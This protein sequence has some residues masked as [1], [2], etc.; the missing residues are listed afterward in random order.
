[1]DRIAFITGT[2]PRI[3]AKLSVLSLVG[4]YIPSLEVFVTAISGS[5]VTLE[6]LSMCYCNSETP[7]PPTRVVDFLAL[8]KLRWIP[9][10]P[11]LGGHILE[12]IRVPKLTCYTGTFSVGFL[13]G[14]FS[15]PNLGTLGFFLDRRVPESNEFLHPVLEQSLSRCHT[16]TF[17]TF[18]IRSDDLDELLA[19][20]AS[21]PYMLG[22]SFK[23]FNIAY[24]GP[25]MRYRR[26]HL[27]TT[28]LGL[29]TTGREIEVAFYD[30]TPTPLDQRPWGV[31]DTYFGNLCSPTLQMW[32][33]SRLCNV[34]RSANI[35]MN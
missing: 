8:R 11:I 32:K 31:C 18:F 21:H 19:L 5:S 27:Q 9:K 10:E 23:R 30:W 33:N 16:L 2:Y 13:A 14:D 34:P 20:I 24:H 4:C 29:D 7:F 17:Y 12:Y 35:V 1:M 25:A 26:E 6:S 15:T 28:K 22:S 3:L